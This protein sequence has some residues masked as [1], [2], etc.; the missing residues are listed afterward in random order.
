M[1]LFI[2]D[3]DGTLADSQH[4]IVAAMEQAF[5]THGLARP[6]RSRVLSVVGLSLDRAVWRLLPDGIDHRLV[7]CVADDYKAAFHELR[8]LEHRE[9][10]Y[11]GIRELIETFARRGDVLL[12]IATGKSRRGLDTILDRERLRSHFHTIQTADAHPSKPHPSMILTALAET[13]ALPTRTLMIGDTTYDMEM[14]RAAGV[15]GLGVAW[16]YH[17]R[18][19]LEQAGAHMVVERSQDL[20]GVLDALLELME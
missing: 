17:G 12:G 3:C 8:R 19:D 15:T 5:A 9:P 11:E 2:F 4:M 1:K 6:E 13:G 7:E 16:G 10:L 18:A 14:A 20:A